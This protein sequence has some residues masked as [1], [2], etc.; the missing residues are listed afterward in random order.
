MGMANVQITRASLPSVSVRMC[1]QYTEVG[2]Q[3]R[4]VVY[5][6]T[7]AWKGSKDFISFSGFWVIL[8][9]VKAALVALPSGVRLYLDKEKTF[10]GRNSDNDIVA[11]EQ[12]VSR[13]HCVVFRN[14]SDFFLED[15][16][17]SNGTYVNGQ[18]IGETVLLR[19]ND[20]LS[21]GKESP[22]YRFHLYFEFFLKA[23]D[24]LRKPLHIA[25]IGAGVVLLL[26][27]LSFLL[28][29]RSQ[30]PGRKEVEK[31][32]RQLE[33]VHG[34]GV[35]PRD[36]AFLAAVEKWME[37]V[38][39]D[40]AFRSTIEQRAAYKDMIEEIL[41]SNNLPADYS[42]IVWAESRYDPNARNS[43]TGAAGLWQLLPRTARANGLRVNRQVDERLDPARS[44]QAAA[45]Y[46]KD[47]VSVFGK[48]SFLLVL[49]AYN[50]GDN[51]VLYGLKQIQDPINDRNFW[52]LYTHNLIPSETKQYVL[53]IVA[54]A[55]V[56]EEL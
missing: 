22:A 35:F 11:E 38:T 13:R 56:A 3:W 25:L 55:I 23:V 49:A 28:F 34:G 21:L 43:R 44:T 36:P 54:L 46:L 9:I 39:R 45:I 8:M 16:K 41:R 32:L 12:Y 14:G 51:A 4:A 42:L 24:F 6:Q 52:Y 26:G 30:S 15:L 10:I 17:S 47:L 2:R 27:F 29:F 37:K 33:R 50:A 53:K 40:E 5:A 19:N 7:A 18:Q 31:G 48:D 20:I 1:L